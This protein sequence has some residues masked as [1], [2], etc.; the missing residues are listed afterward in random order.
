MP[1]V[2]IETRQ[3]ILISIWTLYYEEMRK[4]VIVHDGES[5]C[6]QIH[7]HIQKQSIFLLFMYAYL[8]YFSS[9]V[10]FCLHLKVSVPIV[11]N[12]RCK[13]M[14][15][16]AGRHEFIPDIFLCAGHDLGFVFIPLDIFFCLFRTLVDRKFS[17]ANASNF[18]SLL[19]FHLQKIWFMSGKLVNLPAFLDR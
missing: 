4:N 14:F 5:C 9:F 15:L 19:G 2:H 10:L 3:K 18:F 17:F 7:M 13:S 1:R 6:Q 8:L 16:R 12:D 11:S